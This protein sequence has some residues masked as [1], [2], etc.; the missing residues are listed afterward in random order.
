M[1][2]LGR[3]QHDLRILTKFLH[4]SQAHTRFCLLLLDR[5]NCPGL[6][7]FL[8]G[9]FPSEF[10]QKPQTQLVLRSIS[11][12]VPAIDRSLIN[13]LLAG[14][15]VVSAGEDTVCCVKRFSAHAEGT[16]L[17]GA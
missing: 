15:N 6:L 1:S 8:H 5:H 4:N 10:G 9:D 2:Q 7:R 3:R 12:L 13:I 17:C 16:R 14:L 11:C